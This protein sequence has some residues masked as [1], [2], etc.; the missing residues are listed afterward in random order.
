MS[1]KKLLGVRLPPAVAL[2]LLF[3]AVLTLCLPSCGEDGEPARGSAGATED[4][5]S[6]EPDGTDPADTAAAQ[7]TAL[8]PET[9]TSPETQEEKK[10]SF[11][12]KIASYNIQHAAK[13]IDAVA[14][15]LKQV[16]ADIVGIQE[17]DYLNTRSGGADQPKLIAEA[18]GYP[19]YRFT[20]A[21]DYRGGQY[22][23]MIMSKYPIVSFTVKGLASG[24]EESRSI[25]HAVLD[26]DG[27]EVHF[28]NTHLSYESLSLRTGQF[29]AISKM[30]SDCRHYVLTADFNT[31]DFSEFGVL[32]AP[33]MINRKGSRHVT[34]PGGS[35]AIDNIILSDCFTEISAGTIVSD[36]SDHYILFAET[37]FEN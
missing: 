22:G 32:A 27:T 1:H 20:R 4:I 2:I 9:G 10:V 33:L 16:D 29:E 26:V 14:E 11:K 24:T 5:T 36:A 8:P 19:Y 6:S 23:T 34:F 17:V 30:L 25:G 35:S 37:V 13:G 7:T 15:I 3:T 12:M 31:Q 18:A 21:I 28:F